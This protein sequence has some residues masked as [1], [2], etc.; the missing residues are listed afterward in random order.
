ME[1]EK[2]LEFHHLH[3]GEIEYHRVKSELWY[4]YEETLESKMESGATGISNY[5][6]RGIVP[7]EII[8]QGRAAIKEFVKS[9]VDEKINSQKERYMQ[10]DEYRRNLSYPIELK[11]GEVLLRGR[12]KSLDGTVLTAELLEPYQ[13]ITCLNFGFASAMS[14]HYIFDKNGLNFS[15]YAIKRS[16]GMF[17]EIYQKEKEK[18]ENA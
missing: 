15:D 18:A 10:R 3:E 13:S 12:I 17:K 11:Y 2:E 9:Q 14:G 8:E 6:T 5:E 4:S 7:Q 1:Q 16:E